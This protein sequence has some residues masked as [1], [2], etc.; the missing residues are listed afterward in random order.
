VLTGEAA[1]A[2]MLGEELLQPEVD[3]RR[4]AHRWVW[5][6]EQGGRG[7][8]QTTEAALRH[9]GAHDSPPFGG[10]AHPGGAV[11]CRLIPIALRARSSLTNLVSGTYHL[12]LL[13]HAD[14]RSAWAAVAVNFT[15][16]QFLDGRRDFIPDVIA[17][18]RNNQAPENLLAVLRR[19]PL[20]RFKG[21]G[22]D[23]TADSTTLVELALSLAYHEADAVR[24]LQ[25]LSQASSS[26][27]ALA[28]VASLFGA[29]DGEEVFPAAWRQGIAESERVRSVAGRLVGV[30]PQD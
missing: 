7:L 20:Q 22:A 3:L 4:L 25:E 15:V 17:L 10:E 18:L 24:G 13:T 21:A 26:P 12:A 1:L 11:L 2:T 6:L 9:I 8:D 29:R 16:A 28:L 23:S 14:E 30:G 5:W 27:A 19:V